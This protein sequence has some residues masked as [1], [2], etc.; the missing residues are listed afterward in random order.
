[1]SDI[2]ISYARKDQPRA[3]MLADALAAK[4]W[5]VWWDPKIQS[6]K[7][8]DRVIEQAIAEAKCV[9][10]VWSKY[11]VNSDWVR[12]EATNGLERGIL[13]SVTIDDA[14]ALPLRF[15]QVHTESLTEWDGTA[16]SVKFDKVVADISALVAAS[17]P[18]EPSAQTNGVG[19]VYNRQ[20]PGQIV[21]LCVAGLVLSVSF[22]LLYRNA[23]GDEGAPTALALVYLFAF[24]AAAGLL[25]WG[26]VRVYAHRKGQRLTLK[27]KLAAPV[28]ALL[29]TVL[30]GFLL[31]NNPE[32][33]SLTIR[34]LDKT[35]KTV[36]EGRIKLDLPGTPEQPIGRNGE[37]KFANIPRNRL[38]QPITF[39]VWSPGYNEHVFDTLTDAAQ[40]LEIMLTQPA[41]IK[42]L[43]R[44][45]DAGE[46]PIRDVE[47]SVENTRFYTHSLTDGT[48]FLNITAFA[49]GDEIILRTSHPGYE[50]KLVRLMVTAPETQVNDIV[51]K[52][53]N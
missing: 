7:S 40:P 49:G 14:L 38:R 29:L 13:I 18:S 26:L 43:G 2:F 48:Y 34:V 3:R 21:G 20:V 37:A 10:V 31:P 15:T 1:M 4:G 42:L 25:V 30:S 33:A 5:S 28:G 50:D 53:V 52:P 19:L 8:F 16:T 32:K 45:E 24:C 46:M 39:S 51:L 12:A 23:S 17:G 27:H 6:G 35:Q 41:V 36:N 11:S 22:L 44:I 47:I 9:V